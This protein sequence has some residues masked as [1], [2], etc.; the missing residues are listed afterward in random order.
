MDY[1]DILYDANEGIATITIN[2]PKVYNAFRPKTIEELIQAFTISGDDP[3]IGVVILTGSGDKAFCT[4]GDMNAWHAGE[5][6]ECASWVGIGLPV[7]RLHRLIRSVPKPVIVAVNGY[8]IGGG[9]VLQIVCDLAIASKTAV[10]GQVGPRVGSFDAGFGSAYLARLVGERKAREIW[11]LCRRYSADEAL[12]M[13]LINHVVPPEQ[14]MEEARKWADEI[15]ALS[16]SALKALKYS[17]NA[18]TEHIAGI[19]NLSMASVG[20]YYRTPESAE[21]HN[22][23]KEKRPTNFRKFRKRGF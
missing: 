6:Y 9:N 11:F 17:F 18:D 7:E 21:G 5:G 23:F 20:L 12:Q 4:G 19:T 10:F 1:E 16:P 15:L 22:A 3:E 13:G 14:L 2:R 8:A